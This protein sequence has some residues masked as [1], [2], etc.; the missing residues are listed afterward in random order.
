M[1]EIPTFMTVSTVPINHTNQDF[2]VHTLIN[3][4][5][6][7]FHLQLFS[8]QARNSPKQSWWHSL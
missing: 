8:T 3:A 6:S 7:M 4:L 1:F 5:K 2:I